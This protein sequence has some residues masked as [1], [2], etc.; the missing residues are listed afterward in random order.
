MLQGYLTLAVN[1]ASELGSHMYGV[2]GGD[3]LTIS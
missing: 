3:S 1:M 2:G